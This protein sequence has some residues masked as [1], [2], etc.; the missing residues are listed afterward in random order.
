MPLQI[1]TLMKNEKLK[2]QI[3]SYALLVLGSALFAV[4][5]VMFVNPYHMAPGKLFDADKAA[6][7]DG[8]GKL[9]VAAREEII[10]EKQ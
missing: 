7:F 4:G 1:P 6:Q 8:P 10:L 2:Q 9:I 3:V 5:D